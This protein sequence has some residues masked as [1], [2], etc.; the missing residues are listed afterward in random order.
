LGVLGYAEGGLL[1]FYAAAL[2]TSIHATLVSGYFDSRQR[3]WEEPI[4]RNVFGLLREFG[5]AEIATLIAP[6][7]LLIEHSK[8]PQIDGPP[9][10]RD[11]RGGAAPGKLTTPD[12][13]SVEAEYER[14]RTLIGQGAG[15]GFERLKLFC[16]NE[17]MTTGPVS[18]RALVSFLNELG[19]QT[20]QLKP[21]GE[22]PVDERGTYDPA[23]RQQEQVKELEEFTQTL[24]RQSEQARADFFWTPLKATTLPDWQ[25]A[26]APFRSNFW[27]EVIGRFSLPI[28]TANP[29]TRKAY[30]RPKWVGY[31][32][33]LDVYPDVFAWGYLLL[34]K[35][36]KPGER[37]PVVV[38][39]HGL[40][41]VPSD[42]I[43]DNPDSQGFHYYKAFAARLA[44]RG[45][46]T[47][48][49]HNPYRG[50]DKF[51]RLQRL[52]N[53]LGA[54]LFSI[55][56]AQHSRI[57]DWLA[58][59]PFVDPERIAFYG[60]SYGGKTA[61]RVPAVLDRYSLSICS[62]DFNDWISKNVSVDFPGS[63]MFLGE[64]EMP[65][66]NLGEAFNYAEIAGLIAPRPFMVER[67]HNDGVGIDEWIASEYAKVRR[68]YDRLGIGDRTTIEFFDGPHTINGIGT[69]DFLHNHL[70]WPK[71][72]Q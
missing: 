9:K 43:D 40:E 31:E 51:R 25:S 12:Y 39:Q 6:R 64:Y 20:D 22:T 2:D 35:D 57:L 30:D 33:V 37:R 44:E 67:G 65:E 48:A 27:N 52:A 26:C 28:S 32:V 56:I 61:M 34:P 3:V 36:I 13:T 59:Q 62:G 63:Y 42:V 71:P 70:H 24:L 15:K 72:S 49:P 8:V 54:S 53:P 46:I 55:I 4:Y 19:V 14:A 58:E 29:R 68:L 17:G 21:A 7:A 66:F 50:G 16:G 41:G 47:F 69:F 11:H 45:F 38:C 10:T 23:P 18:D 60:L 1:A 5:D